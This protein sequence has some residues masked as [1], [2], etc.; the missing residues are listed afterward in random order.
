MNNFNSKKKKKKGLERQTKQMGCFGVRTKKEFVKYQNGVT[1]EKLSQRSEAA[2]KQNLA[3]IVISK[4]LPIYLE[5]T[6]NEKD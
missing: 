6:S 2:D 3:P 4:L 5:S 1:K